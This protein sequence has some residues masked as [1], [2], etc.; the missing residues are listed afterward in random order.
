MGPAVV[1][2]VF[3]V[4]K[5]ANHASEASSFATYG[6]PAPGLFADAIGVL[7]IFGGLALLLGVALGPAA[8]LLAGDMIGAIIVSGVARGETVSLTL[9][10]ALLAAMC[11]LLVIEWRKR[12]PRR[13]GQ[14]RG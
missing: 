5:F 13:R 14:G 9:A 4:G 7:E 12:R 2:V 11:A 1:F 3:G 6:L 8:L 10:P